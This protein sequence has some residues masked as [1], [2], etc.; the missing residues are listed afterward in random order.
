MS[1]ADCNSSVASSH[2]EV[3]KREVLEE[4]KHESNDGLEIPLSNANQN[5]HDN[6]D[7]TVSES[8]SHINSFK[9]E[10]EESFAEFERL[11]NEN[12]RLQAK[13]E[14]KRRKNDEAKEKIKSLELQLERKDTEI[15]A[16]LNFQKKLESRMTAF[17]E[18]EKLLS[19]KEKELNERNMAGKLEIAGQDV[20]MDHAVQLIQQREDEIKSLKSKLQDATSE[21]EKLEKNLNDLLAAKER[22]GKMS[23]NDSLE[24][25]SNR[26][27]T[28]EPKKK[29]SFRTAIVSESAPH[30]STEM[31]AARYVETNGGNVI[32]AAA[33]L[34]IVYFVISL[35]LKV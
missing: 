31:K 29:P 25:V 10:Y 35:F 16:V 30:P 17:V 8:P 6:V 32:V 34:V 7:S 5:E 23:R 15:M 11:K 28:P 14:K 22:F 2:D 33:A 27:S 26:T 4:E 19:L 13:I 24:N 3:L 1:G 20:A 21:K 9:R 12:L 18:K